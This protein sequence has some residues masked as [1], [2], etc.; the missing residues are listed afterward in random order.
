M[1]LYLFTIDL[2]S[3]EKLNKFA[4]GCITNYGMGAQNR[5]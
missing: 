2:Q 4:I 3:Q 5:K 1:I